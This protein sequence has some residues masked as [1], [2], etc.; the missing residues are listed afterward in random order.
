MTSPIKLIG[1]DVP[2]VTQQNIPQGSPT[3]VEDDTNVGEQL[4]SANMSRTAQMYTSSIQNAQQTLASTT[5]NTQR[6]LGVAYEYDQRAIASRPRDPLNGDGFAKLGD[7]VTRFLEADMRLQEQ[8][9][10]AQELKLKEQREAEYFGVTTQ[11]DELIGTL[12][13]ELRT[14][15][16]GFSEI[17]RQFKKLVDRNQNLTPEFRSKLYGQFYGA[18]APIRAEYGRQLV[19]NVEKYRAEYTEYQ[20]KQLDIEFASLITGLKTSQTPETFNANLTKAY[21]RLGEVLKDE[22]FTDIERLQMVNGA[23]TLVRQ[24]TFESEENKAATIKR[25]QDFQRAIVEGGRLKRMRASGEI[26]DADYDAQIG[27]LMESTKMPESVAKVYGRRYEIEN[28]TALLREQEEYRTLVEKN[29]ARSQDA[30]PF[31]DLMLGY[32]VA[33]SRGSENS[34][35]VASLKPGTRNYDRVMG[36]IKEYQ[37]YDSLRSEVSKQN[38]MLQ[39]DILKNSET[40]SRGVI[41]RLMGNSNVNLE[42]LQSWGFNINPATLQILQKGQLTPE[43]R[44]QIDN[45]MRE[46]YITQNE[47]IARIQRANVEKLN[48][49]TGVMR[50]RGLD[51]G[52]DK[53]PT[54]R[55]EAERKI[56]RELQSQE[57]QKQRQFSDQLQGR[58]PNFNRPRLA[59]V[60]H[61]S[62]QSFAPF[63]PGAKF[64]IPTNGEHRN[65]R[66]THFHAGQDYS[67]PDGTEII[68]HVPMQVVDIKYDEAGYGNYITTKGSDGKYYRYSHLSRR[69]SFRR[70]Q[71]LEAG[72]TVGLVGNTGRSTGAHL[73]FE[74]RTNP[75][76][77]EQG[78]LDPIQYMRQFSNNSGVQ[79]R[80][81]NMEGFYGSGQATNTARGSIPSNAFALGGGLF[82]LNG[83]IYEGETLK[84]RQETQ[85]RPSAPI[86]QNNNSSNKSDYKTSSKGDENFGYAALARDSAL[87]RE[88]H[89][90][91]RSMGFPAQWLADLIAFETG[92]RFSATVDNNF[93][94]KGLIQFSEEAAREVGTSH[95]AFN[96]MTP[97][98][99]MKYVE[100]YLRNRT[101][102]GKWITS[103]FDLLA[104]VW[105]GNSSPESMKTLWA[106]PNINDCGVTGGTPGNGCVS[107]RQYTE[108]LGEHAGRRYDSPLTR[109]QRLQ[110]HLRNDTPQLQASNSMNRYQELYGQTVYS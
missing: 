63:K 92:G 105:Y 50:S 17:E 91:S 89:R 103:P 101:N 41:S 51:Q 56:F 42:Q 93:G 80:G 14:N 39:G 9:R 40:F 19:D 106:N 97:A 68:A 10:Q 90:V 49:L 64:S 5:E 57:Q 84:R 20:G 32:I 54:E 107:W 30:V 82:L 44:Q 48:R 3:L 16:G 79:A 29:E 11:V 13:T 33:Q 12:Q 74:V 87:R 96:S 76:Y 36:A 78:T 15:P 72:S 86:R 52:V 60:P 31:S 73:H 45:Q 95:G 27:F 28:A 7:T 53:F 1:V 67:A 69:P 110:S 104:S 58:S 34:A 6:A 37:E 38:L 98:Q 88:I 75:N 100:R 25:A 99:Q 8:Q 59:V 71:L 65:N 85:Y 46:L 26:S 43:E 66:G 83:E 81:R 21:D 55:L 108:R 61:Q 22:R 4:V 18:V 35:I 2:N 109:R 24:A 94:Y 47:N 62:G 70:G 77:G 102:N 23:M